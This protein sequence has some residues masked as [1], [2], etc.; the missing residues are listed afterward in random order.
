MKKAILKQ[1]ADRLIETGE[2]VNESGCGSW[3]TRFYK[4]N[5]FLYGIQYKDGRLYDVISYGR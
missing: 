4:L 3:N 5:G 1:R 2:F